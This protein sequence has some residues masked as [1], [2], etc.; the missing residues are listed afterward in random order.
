MRAIVASFVALLAVLAPAAT[1][2][3]SEAV[4]TPLRVL[5]VGNSLTTTNDLPA[6]V[7]S[8]A[9]AGGREL[10]VGT[11]TFDGFSLED[12]W[13]HGAV[14]QALAARAWDVAIMQQGPSALPE[15][16]VN[17]RE[18]ATRLADAARAERIRPALLTVWPESYRRTAL[19]DVIVSYRGAAQ[20]SGSELF[21]AGEAWH[22]AWQCHTAL[23][24][25]GPDGFHPSRVGTYT[26]ALVVYGRLF[27]A[28][29]LAPALGPQWMSAGVARLTQASAARALGRRVP[30][31]R[32]CGR[33]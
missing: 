21:P 3:R 11:V 33:A 8:L 18:Y 7:A 31:A 24:L 12:H 22:A 20:T 32:R 6:T 16:Q 29:L 17:L 19:S 4:T 30:A 1:E 27:K 9:R 14:R 25:Y 2:A 5:F 28:P 26:A 15:S 13:N 23:G 10:E